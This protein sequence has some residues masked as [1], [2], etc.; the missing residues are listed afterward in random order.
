MAI[1]REQVG[2]FFRI[3]ADSKQARAEFR[4]FETVIQTGLRSLTPLSIGA[5]NSL[6]RV[7]TSLLSSFRAQTT[8]ANA[9]KPAVASVEQQILKLFPAYAKVTN[10]AQKAQLAQKLFA[11]GLISIPPAASAATVA[12]TT[13]DAA[14]LPIAATLGLIAAAVGGLALV[15]KGL[16]GLAEGAAEVGKQVQDVS[17]KTGITVRNVN[18]LRIAASEAGVEFG[19]VRRMLDQFITRMDDAARAKDQT[20]E[21]ASAFRRV[22]VD[23]KA[24]L[25]DANKEFEK[26]IGTLAQ[27]SSATNLAADAQRIFG[28]RN[29]DAILVIKQL[30]GSL[31]EY[32]RRLNGIGVITDQQARNAVI[33]ARAIKQ[34]E[35]S[36]QGLTL[37]AGNALVP[38]FITLIDLLKTLIQVSATYARELGTATARARDFVGIALFPMAQALIFVTSK[39]FG[40]I[41]GIDGLNATLRAAPAYAR[42]F[43][44][45]MAEVALVLAKLSTG[46]FAGAVGSAL[47]LGSG[48]ALRG[49]LAAAS[50]AKAA[51]LAE[52]QANRARALS[53]LGGRPPQ[54]DTNTGKAKAAKQEHDFTLELLKAQLEALKIQGRQEV[55]LTEQAFKEKTLAAGNY[56]KII[57]EITERIL[58]KEKEVFA[59]ERAEI[60]RTVKDRTERAAKIQQLANQEAQAENRATNEKAQ[61]REAARR[62]LEAFFKQELDDLEKFQDAYNKLL[63]ETGKARIDTLKANA[64]ELANRAR[65]EPRF[66]QAARAANEL[67]EREQLRF[68]QEQT[69]LQLRGEEIRLKALDVYGLHT[70]EIEARYYELRG[71]AAKQFQIRRQAIEDEAKRQGELQNPLSSRSFFGDAF[72]DGLQETE[73]RMG[74]FAAFF[75]DWQAELA[76][77]SAETGSLLQTTFGAITDALTE[78]ATAFVLTGQTGPAAFRQLAA[79]V[80]LAVA[81]MAAT[82]AIFE[83]AEGFAALARGFF[84]DPRGFV[85]AGHH[86]TAA[87]IYGTIGVVAGIAG[88]AIAPSSGPQG[89]FAGETRPGQRTIEQGERSRPDPQV[90]I[91][92]AEYQPGIIVE[93]IKQ[94]YQ[95]NGVTRRMLRGDMLGEQAT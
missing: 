79:G 38:T 83:L 22:G 74:A 41:G 68:E 23:A 78:M 77:R 16:F 25:T 92:R 65:T 86:F 30:N 88:R 66:L 53:G 67:L 29:D 89:N 2:L 87:A 28:L 75:A 24:G 71:E 36:I 43:G 59:A 40:A 73:S 60:N 10:E 47:E 4:Q 21:M 20:T 55:E 85:E 54:F 42:V 6:A 84:G 49:A 58:A 69:D 26:A 11:Q 82:K 9:L 7:A 35:N 70:Q 50:G 52:I 5:S 81:K 90:I 80:I 45:A 3:E 33:F 91:I 17:T 27:Y 57:I 76:Q 56:E 14:L 93:Q 18:L 95:T 8:S 63:D 31:S 62:E 32:E 1:T 34:L 51:A 15:T 39:L 61:A 13:L 12:V 46:D 48:K 44:A 19:V 72:A 37:V 64:D 94:D